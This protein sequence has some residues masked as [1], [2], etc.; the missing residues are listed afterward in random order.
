MDRDFIL[1]HSL[2]PYPHAKISGRI[3]ITASDLQSANENQV[4]L[5]H[6]MNHQI[7]GRFSDAR[8]AFAM[9]LEGEYGTIPDAAKVILKQGLEQT[10]VGVD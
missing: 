6:I 7:K 1:F 5:I 10:E 8:S 2:V 4:N 3:L 9:L